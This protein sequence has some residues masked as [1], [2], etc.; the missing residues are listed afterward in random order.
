MS[1]R[2]MSTQGSKQA[3][4]SV[5]DEGVYEG[6][7]QGRGRAEG[8]EWQAEEFGPCFWSQGS[9]SVDVL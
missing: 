2:S 8:F 7:S 1:G 3:S 6:K 4:F 9:G 5:V